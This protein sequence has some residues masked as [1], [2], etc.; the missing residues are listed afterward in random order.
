M[1]AGR[2]RLPVRGALA[3][4]GSRFAVPW[5]V[6]AP[7][8][9]RPDARRAPDSL[10]AFASPRMNGSPVRP[11]ARPSPAVAALLAVAALVLSGCRIEVIAELDLRPDGSGT[12]V[13]DLELDRELLNLFSDLDLDPVAEVEAAVGEQPD[14]DLEVLVERGDGLRLRL[15]HRGDDPAGAL[16]DLSDGLVEG[17]PGLFSDLEVRVLGHDELELGGTVELAPPDT[18]G[19]ID[20]DGEPVGP[21]EDELRSLMIQQVGAAL[22]VT[23]P[24]EVRA[25]DADD[26]RD[27]TLQWELPVAEPVEVLARSEASSWPENALVVWAAAGLLVVVIAA[28]V[29]LLIRRRRG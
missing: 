16:G 4:S 10:P 19:A 23:M 18:P 29:W 17:D 26:A 25:H 15:E 3:G 5:Q 13:V 28:V 14:W 11:P 7:G 1:R 12:A 6:P 22:V 24:G 27:R 20:E 9:P 8:P 21:D 2:L